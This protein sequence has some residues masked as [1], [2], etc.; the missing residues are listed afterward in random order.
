[1]SNLSGTGGVQPNVISREPELKP[2]S[3]PWSLHMHAT[4]HTPTRPHAPEAT[5]KAR[6]RPFVHFSPFGDQYS[7]GLLAKELDIED[8]VWLVGSVGIAVCDGEN[9][10]APRSQLAGWPA[11]LFKKVR[12]GG[13]NSQMFLKPAQARFEARHTTAVV[14]FCFQESRGVRAHYGDSCATHAGI[15]LRPC[16]SRSS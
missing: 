3:G 5:Q 14:T 10:H 2:G 16:R 12:H 6:T 7:L 9:T 1:M 13:C 8:Q 11:R 4:Y 15:R